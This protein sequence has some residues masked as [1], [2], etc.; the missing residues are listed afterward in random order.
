MSV[1]SLQLIVRLKVLATQ[2][3]I[4]R[5]YAKHPSVVVP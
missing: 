2:V 4:I 1:G 5:K 3:K